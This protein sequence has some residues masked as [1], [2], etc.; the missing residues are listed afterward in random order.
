MEYAREKVFR[1]AGGLFEG[2]EPG[3]DCFVVAALAQSTE[4]VNGERGK[5]NFKSLF[6]AIEREQA[7]RG[8]L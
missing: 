7:L 8:N 5:G 4:A 6:E 2:D 3:A 1:A